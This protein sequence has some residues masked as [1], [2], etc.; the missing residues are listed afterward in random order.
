MSPERFVKGESERTEGPLRKYW[1]LNLASL[2]P[3]NFKS[4][5]TSQRAPAGYC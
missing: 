1:A 4:I 3:P 5:K 2:Q